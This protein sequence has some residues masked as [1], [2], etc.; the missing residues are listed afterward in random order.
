VK[1]R[2]GLVAAAHHTRV[3]ACYESTQISLFPSF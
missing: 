1:I 2:L 3:L